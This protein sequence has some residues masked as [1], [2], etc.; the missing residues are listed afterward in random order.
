MRSED[1]AKL[2]KRGQRLRRVTYFGHCTRM[3]PSRY[4]HI[5]LYVHTDGARSRGR[6]RKR[7]FDNVKEDRATL[8][9]TVPDADRLAK[10]RPG[11][12]SLIH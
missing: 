7:W 9:L 11:W 4:P 8:Q 6:P 1:L 10:D 2:P 3:D 12:R 5:L